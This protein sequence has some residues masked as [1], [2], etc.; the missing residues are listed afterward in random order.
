MVVRRSPK[1]LTGV[2]SSLPLLNGLRAEA[3][4]LFKLISLRNREPLEN[5]GQVSYVMSYVPDAGDSAYG[6]QFS[7][8]EVEL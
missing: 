6:K 5:N 7:E 1:P 4:R 8:K 2:R 3:F